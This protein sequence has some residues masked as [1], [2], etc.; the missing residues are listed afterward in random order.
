MSNDFQQNALSWGEQ[1]KVW[2]Q[3]IPEQIKGYEQKW[4]LEVLEPFPLNYNYVAP[5]TRRDG[6]QA[7]LKIGFPADREFK[8]ETEALELFNGNG[9]CKLLEADIEG[10]AILIER[11]TPGTP[12][13]ELEDDAEATRILSAVMKRLHKPLPSA[14]TLLTLPE[15]SEGLA[16]YIAKYENSGGKLPIA[17]VRKAA[18]LFERLIATSSELVLMHGDLHHDNVLLS[19]EHGW[20]AIDPKGVAAEAAYEVA[21]LI[22]DPYEKLKDIDDLVPLL[23]QR[24]N[25]F[26]EELGFDRQRLLDWCFAHSILSAVWSA[27]GANYSGHMLRVAQALDSLNV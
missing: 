27:E 12:L 3:N 10:S 22:G 25:I 2:L 23:T 9:I 4:A 21:P 11:L 19:D 8:T 26:S 13:S 6:S 16:A 7:V 20:T 24:L 15:R 18:A 5:V 17:D 14:H 1:G